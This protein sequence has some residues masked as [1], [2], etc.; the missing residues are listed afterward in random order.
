MV[1]QI[2]SAKKGGTLSQIEGLKKGLEAG[3]AVGAVVEDKSFAL[4]LVD[5]FL[6]MYSGIQITIIGK[7]D[8]RF[9]M[10]MVLSKTEKKD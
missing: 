7:E 10:R 6:S 3:D 5:E 9:A 2:G 8:K 1:I 4:L